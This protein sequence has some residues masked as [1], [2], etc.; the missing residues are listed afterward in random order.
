MFQAG[1]R[2]AT[3]KA[4]SPDRSAPAPSIRRTAQEAV[5]IE[6][7]PLKSPTNWPI[8]LRLYAH[9]RMAENGCIEWCGFLADNGYGKI[10]LP[11]CFVGSQA[12]RSQYVH[13]VMWAIY[14]G[15]IPEGF[16]VLHH[17]DN[18]KCINPAHLFLGTAQDNVDDMDNKGRRVSAPMRGERHP[19]HKLSLSEVRAI[20]E[21]SAKGHSRTELA[22][23]FCISYPTISRIVT[24]RGWVDE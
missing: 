23:M 14:H 17:C 8:C 2:V 18:R 19:R 3:E 6:R 1:A 13:R 11:R 10:G 22:E 21:L 9:S 4:D 12:S 15:A 20:R 24:N 16:S 5:M 7:H